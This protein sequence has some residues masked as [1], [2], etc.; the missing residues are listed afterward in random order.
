MNIKAAAQQT[1]LTPHTIRAWEKRYQVLTP[2]R[3]LSGRRTYSLKDI[4]HLQRLATLVRRGHSISSIASLSP[5]KLQQLLSARRT[6]HPPRTQLPEA[7]SEIQRATQGILH[8]L[9]RFDLGAMAPQIA[10]A[11]LRFDVRSFV[12]G[13]AL[14]LMRDVGI[15]VDQ[16]KLLIA[17]EHA[18][19][20]ML[21]DQL[22]Q[23]LKLL[24]TNN[25]AGPRIALA[26]PGGDIHEFG[27]ILSAI[28]AAENGWSVQYLGPNLPPE[29]LAQA[30]KKLETQI[31][32]LGTTFVPPEELALP[33]R[34]YLKTLDAA[35]PQH[36]RLWI[37]GAAASDGPLPHLRLRRGTQWIASLEALEAL[38]KQQKPKGPS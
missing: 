10:K 15:R 5:K 7:T 32:L 6:E 26:T 37:G 1:G 17:Q 3:S 24:N 2:D 19:S 36:V 34:E 23:M 22:G 13:V 11:A 38:L 31:V 18:L 35:L 8:L 20:I 9:D 30:S 21:R 12:Y 27:I 14:P 16:G 33:W 25:D 29:Q 4:E 28:L